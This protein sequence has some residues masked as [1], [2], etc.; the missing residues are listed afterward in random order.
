M[1]LKEVFAQAFYSLK[2]HRF[3]A[4]LTMLGIAW[5]IVTVVVL[6][7][8]GHG[9]RNALMF[10]FRN[11]FSDGTV[12]VG[13]GRPACRRAERAAHP[14]ES[15]TEAIQELG[16]VTRPEYRVDAVSTA[17]ADDAVCGRPGEYG[18]CAPR[19]LAPAIHQ[20]RDVEKQRRVA[21]LGTG[22]A[23][24]SATFRPSVATAHQRDVVRSH[25]G[26]SAAVVAFTRFHVVFIHSTMN[27]VRADVSRLP[28]LSRRDAVPG[29]R[30]HQAGPRSAG[31]APQ[32][33]SAR[34][35]RHPVDASEEIERVDGMAGGLMIVLVFTDPDC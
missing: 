19:H 1:L 16:T 29:G 2:D 4:S 11:A 33:R 12:R 24:C 13:N 3:R 30:G 22:A 8:Y 15:R 6:M 10:G 27:A 18:S 9:F 20:R 35:A 23:S 5:G 32:V 7:S 34:R 28:G 25:R 14:D 17:R 31:A 26:P 21:L